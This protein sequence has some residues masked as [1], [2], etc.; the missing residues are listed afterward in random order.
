[1]LKGRTGNSAESYT[2]VNRNKP[3]LEDRKQVI[4][5]LVV[6]DLCSEQSLC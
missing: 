4:T 3:S 1:M 2:E 6:P 5:Q